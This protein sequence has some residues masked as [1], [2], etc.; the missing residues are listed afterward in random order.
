M[1]FF[2]SFLH[3]LCNSTFIQTHTA[4]FG[5][6]I[7]LYPIQSIFSPLLSYPSHSAIFPPTLAPFVTLFDLSSPS[8]NRPP[9]HKVNIPYLHYA[10]GLVGIL[11][12][13]VQTTS[14]LPTSD[15][16]TAPTTARTTAP[17]TK[18]PR[19][20]DRYVDCSDDQKQKLGQG[21]ADAATLAS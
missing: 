7:N 12:S 1:H 8:H 15:P 19:V 14:A 18:F 13:L 10:A 4:T 11:F 21:F 16:T 17:S 2:S 3:F 5:L 6:S 9:A 20:L